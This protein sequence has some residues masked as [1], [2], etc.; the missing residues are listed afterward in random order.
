MSSGS[1]T[2]RASGDVPAASEEEPG[3][4]DATG[5]D[6]TDTDG[7]GRSRGADP[8]PASTLWEYLAH[9]NSLIVGTHSGHNDSL[10]VDEGTVD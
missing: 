8:P 6:W 2:G 7:W 5:D 10:F 1:I 4:S 3:E 9:I